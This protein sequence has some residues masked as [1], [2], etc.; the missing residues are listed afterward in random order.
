MTAPATKRPERRR[1][2]G[3]YPPFRADSAAPE[4]AAIAPTAPAAAGAAARPSTGREEDRE[5]RSGAGNAQNRP[6]A[7]GNGLVQGDRGDGRLILPPVVARAGERA[8]RRFVEFFTAEIRNRNTRGAYG[9]AVSR[10]L[11]WCEARGFALEQL[12]PVIVAAYV[13]QL[14]GELAAPSVKQHLAA[15]RMLFDYLV[16]G[17]VLR[18][19]PAAAVRGP[20]LVIRT[21]K[22]PVMFEEEARQLL[23]SID[24]GDVA[25][26]RDRAIFAVMTYTFARVGAVIGLRVRDYATMGR[27]SW[28][29]LH[30]KGGRHLQVPA[31]RKAAEAVEAYLELAGIAEDRDGPLFRSMRAGVL[32][33]RPLRRQRVWDIVKRRARAAGLSPD[34]CCHSFRASGITNYLDHGG[35]LERAAAIA[36]HASTR[37]TQLY[38]RLD[39]EITLDEI[40]RI[41]I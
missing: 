28:F 32:T 35:T 41:L 4:P 34:V 18:S 38:N 10:F 33:A 29:V 2:E 16:T 25:G 30:E 36:G 39:D 3:K 15:L 22:T 12:E 27:R 26:A 7:A 20:R 24:A 37:T 1:L 19:N 17:Q 21:G 11:A 6:G 8:Q 23:T 31:H 14:A 9:V 40:E 5:E 13:E